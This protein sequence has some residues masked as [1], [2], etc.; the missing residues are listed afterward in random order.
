MIS[1]ISCRSETQPHRF[2]C[3]SAH[4]LTI[5]TR[6]T[7]TEMILFGYRCAFTATANCTSCNLRSR[8]ISNQ[9]K[10]E[11]AD[12]WAHFVQILVGVGAVECC[13][14]FVNSAIEQDA[15]LVQSCAARAQ[16]GNH[17]NHIVLS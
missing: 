4:L 6:N 8:L 13:C 10:G 2:H 16:D 15:L 17:M 14:N 1:S 11:G 7:Q 9:S 5:D 12:K 3:P